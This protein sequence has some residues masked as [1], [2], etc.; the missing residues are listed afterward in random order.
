MFEFDFECRLQPGL[1]FTIKVEIKFEFDFEFKS[2]LGLE[3]GGVSKMEFEFEFKFRFQ[4]GLKFTFKLEFEFEFDFGL[5]SELAFEVAPELEFEL[6]SSSIHLPAFLS[7]VKGTTATFKNNTN[8]H[9]PSSRTR[10]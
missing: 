3:F 9:F 2:E 7:N 4:P 5:K 1:K 6:A 8:V 10:A